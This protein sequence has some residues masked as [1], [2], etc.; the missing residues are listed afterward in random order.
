MIESDETGE[1]R[2]WT[3]RLDPV[4]SPSNDEAEQNG[5]VGGIA[6]ILVRAGRGAMSVGSPIVDASHV[7]SGSL[8]ALLD[9][10]LAYLR[11]RPGIASTRA[12]WT[13]VASSQAG[14]M[15]YWAELTGWTEAERIRFRPLR[16]DVYDRLEDRGDIIKPPGQGEP[17]EVSPAPGR[18][19]GVVAPLTSRDMTVD[20]PSRASRRS[21]RR[22]RTVHQ[23]TGSILPLIHAGLDRA[24]RRAAARSGAHGRPSDRNGDLGRSDPHL[25]RHLRCSFARTQGASRLRDQRMEGVDSRADRLD[26]CGA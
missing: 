25:G 5:R 21:G 22:G 12:G 15:P 16:K 11:S 8:T 14:L 4:V 9:D 6:G 1:P 24:R 20:A 18:Q 17:I 13:R 26:P 10:A 2:T 23:V 19:A 3:T 7:E